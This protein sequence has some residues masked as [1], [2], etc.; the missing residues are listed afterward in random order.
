MTDTPVPILIDGLP[1]KALQS[2][3]SETR[4]GSALTLHFHYK[5]WIGEPKVLTIEDVPMAKASQIVHGIQA[6]TL[7]TLIQD[8]LPM[9]T[10]D[11]RELFLSGL[12]F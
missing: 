6:W 12:S 5:S 4:P 7:G 2:V 8:A 9:L 10:T 3:T 1:Y 11:E